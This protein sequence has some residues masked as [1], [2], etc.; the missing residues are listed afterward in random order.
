MR[1]AILSD[2]H[3][4]PLALEA[5]LA[6]IHAQ[7]GADEY[8]VLGDLVAIGYDPAT[9]LERLRALPEARY[10]RGNTD[11]NLFEN[12]LQLVPLEAI[13]AD[14]QLLPR[15]L[16]FATSFAWTKGYLTATEW[17]DWLTALPLETR[18]TLP[19]GTRVLG[20]HA[21]P[22]TDDGAGLHP[23]QTEAEI[24]ASL[25]GCEADLVFCGHT[26]ISMDRTVNGV[27]VVNQGSVSL[28]PFKERLARPNPTGLINRPASA[29]PLACYVLLQAGQDGYTLQ[30]HFVA[31]DRQA[32]GE[33]FQASGHPGGEKIF[34]DWWPA[35]GSD[36]VSHE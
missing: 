24:Q 10:T 28:P 15:A 33:A 9:V 13:Q 29:N 14:L 4:N 3:G 1:L 35:P 34:T 20:V 11:R 23:W 17:L 26:H 31:Y 36:E 16:A 25:E 30:H 12:L 19:D 32:V 27:R 6:D 8:W 21:A 22:G 2:I 18:I 5:V 7:G